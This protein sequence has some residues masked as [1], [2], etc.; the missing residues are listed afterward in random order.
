MTQKLLNDDNIIAV[1]AALHQIAMSDCKLL[2]MPKIKKSLKKITLLFGMKI[3]IEKPK[4]AEEKKGLEKIEEVNKKKK[5]PDAYRS[6]M[7]AMEQARVKLQ[8]QYDK[9]AQEWMKKKAEQEE[10]KQQQEIKDWEKHQQGK[11]Y[12]SKIGARQTVDKEREQLEQQ[13]KIKGKKGFKPDYNPLTGMG[14]GGSSYRP[15]RRGNTG[16]G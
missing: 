13:A 8:E 14:S 4:P 12:N 7:E 6:K 3:K 9:S 5:D 10:K 1:K 16:G 15:A 11:S 2:S